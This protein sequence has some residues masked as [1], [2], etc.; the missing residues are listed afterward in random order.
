MVIYQKKN[1]SNNKLYQR[2]Q[3]HI[4]IDSLWLYV[5][6]FYRNNLSYL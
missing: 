3:I 6:Y 4:V 1:Y 2:L 5:A